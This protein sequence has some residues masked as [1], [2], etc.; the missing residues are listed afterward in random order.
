MELRAVHANQSANT[1]HPADRLAQIKSEIAIL[2]AE[3][4]ELRAFLIANPDHRAGYLWE[5]NVHAVERRH[6]SIGDAEKV[7]SQDTI[8]ALAKTTS[9]VGVWLKRRPSP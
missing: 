7:L 8:D 9:T 2:E 5:A 4:A 1:P 6:I 3:R